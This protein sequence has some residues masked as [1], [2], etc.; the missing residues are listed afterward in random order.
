MS[1]LLIPNEP[2]CVTLGKSLM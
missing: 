2:I 1:F